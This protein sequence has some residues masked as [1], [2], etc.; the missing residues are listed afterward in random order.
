LFE[1][2]WFRLSE[3]HVGRNSEA[4]SAVFGRTADYAFGQFALPAEFPAAIAGFRGQVAVAKNVI[5]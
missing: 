5:E 1:D 4:Y 3:Q 2:S